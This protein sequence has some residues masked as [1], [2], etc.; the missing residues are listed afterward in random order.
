MGGLFLYAGAR[1]IAV[2]AR[3]EVEVSEPT[4]YL[5]TESDIPTH[6]VN[7]ASD[8]PGTPAPPLHPATK[9]PLGPRTSRRSSPWG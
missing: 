3:T 5:L 8:L 6:W 1:R 4:K 7:L 9:E 2:R